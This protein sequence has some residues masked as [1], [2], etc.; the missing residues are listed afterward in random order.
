MRRLQ[1][2]PTGENDRLVVDSPIENDITS[3]KRS[4]D[5]LYDE[6]LAIRVR[7]IWQPTCT[8]TP[9]NVPNAPS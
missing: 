6:I 7:L 5:L 1:N 3:V 9:L 4:K 8:W 2:P